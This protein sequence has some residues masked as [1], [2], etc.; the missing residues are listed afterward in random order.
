MFTAIRR[1]GFRR[2]SL[3]ERDG[4]LT[5]DRLGSFA[6]AFLGPLRPHAGFPL[7]VEPFTG[8]PAPVDL[9]HLHP[10]VADLL[11]HTIFVPSDPRT[12]D[13]D[14]A[15]VLTDAMTHEFE[16]RAQVGA[17]CP[18]DL[19][20]MLRRPRP[21]ETPMPPE[22]APDD[23]LPPGSATRISLAGLIP[24]RLRL[25]AIESETGAILA[26]TA[27]QVRERYHLDDPH[28]WC[29]MWVDWLRLPARSWIERLAL[30]VSAADALVDTGPGTDGDAPRFRPIER[31]GIA[32]L[33]DAGRKL[34]ALHYLLA[35]LDARVLTA[36]D[37]E[38]LH[39]LYAG[40]LAPEHRGWAGLRPT[41]EIHSDGCREK[42]VF[43]YAVPPDVGA[44][45]VQAATANEVETQVEREL[46][47]ALLLVPAA[48]G[49]RCPV[50]PGACVLRMLAQHNAGRDALGPRVTAELAVMDDGAGTHPL[51][52]CDACIERILG[53]LRAV[54]LL[55]P[56][57]R[58]NRRIV[59]NFLLTHYLLRCRANVV[60]GSVA[61]NPSGALPIVAWKTSD[62]VRLPLAAQR[63]LVRQGQA[64]FTALGRGTFH[65]MPAG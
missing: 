28:R 12:D 20:D 7:I 31:P 6:A 8:F 5:D 64:R 65:L 9:R 47:D 14:Q 59:Y 15:G 17:C 49:V 33:D 10:E 37:V 57:R 1:R 4:T 30:V 52:G 63:R 18:P 16:A 19:L 29:A 23:V 24:W 41:L 21:F 51:C 32:P 50:S 46:D 55:M 25:A 38:V 45:R 11:Q 27:L 54:F 39:A 43:T 13:L 42:T 53:R 36:G 62:F 34:R 40:S 61:G 48:N 60:S 2:L 35:R 58:S 26:S 3:H 56:F 22:I 44:E